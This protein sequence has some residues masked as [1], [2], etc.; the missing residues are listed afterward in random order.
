MEFTL[1]DFGLTPNQSRVYLELV[2]HPGSSAG[3]LA[4]HLSIDR[5][6]IYGIIESLTEKGLIYYSLSNKR[7][8]F[9]SSPPE[10]LLADLNEKRKKASEIIKSL[11]SLSS[12]E[13]V[14]PPTFEVYEGKP[15]LKMYFREVLKSKEFF[16]L[17]G[18]GRLNILNILQC[19]HP[20]Y[21][22]ELKQKRIRGKILCSLENKARWKSN[23]ADTNV[24]IKAL[25]GAGK[26]SSITILKDQVIFSSEGKF[27]KILILKDSDHA[28][29]LRHYFS[30]LWTLA[31]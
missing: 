14:P 3:S 12:E 11:K 6:F 15:G 5:S 7:K 1:Q 20:H 2:K 27:P 31:K 26:E 29:S 25:S 28:H 24:K 10:N 17:G 9:Y 8:V 22:K 23:L 19:E 13:R 30:Y 16:S 4:K 18:G 21:F